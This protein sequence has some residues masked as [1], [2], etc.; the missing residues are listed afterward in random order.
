MLKAENIWGGHSHPQLKALQRLLDSQ[1]SQNPPNTPTE[2][3]AILHKV[4]YQFDIAT[5]NLT[6]MKMTIQRKSAK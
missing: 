2:L 4:K 1:L 5:K 6:L 3:D